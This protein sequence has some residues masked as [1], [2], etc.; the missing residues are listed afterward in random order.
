[1]S[2]AKL[3]T[4]LNQLRV[5]FQTLVNEHRDQEHELRKEKLKHETNVEGLINRYDEDMM[6]KQVG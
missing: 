1:M 5:Q 6:K 3:Q 2:R 4:E